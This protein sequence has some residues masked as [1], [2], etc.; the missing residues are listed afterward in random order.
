[1]ISR[2]AAVV[3]T[4]LALLVAGC[5]DDDREPSSAAEPSVVALG[6]SIPLNEASTCPGCDGFIDTYAEAVGA[7]V[8]NLAVHGRRVQGVADQL[9][10]GEAADALADADLVIVSFGA[11]DYPPYRG[12]QQPCRVADTP[13]FEAA[14]AALAATT[15]ACVG[16]VVRSTLRTAYDALAEVLDEAPDARLAVLAPY[17]F[18]VGWPEVEG[19]PDRAMIADAQR[20]MTYAV[21]VWR[22]ALCAV[23]ADLHGTCID[24]YTAFNGPD[25]DRP[26][27]DL[28]SSDH[29]HPSQE[30]NDLIRDLLLE[31]NLL[32]TRAS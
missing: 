13:T 17:D 32:P 23:V 27:G 8:D 3:V 21:R 15:T 2:T 11:N 1:M 20:T 25:G 4:S 12:T 28:L 22:D 19:V 18:W 30:G 14:V 16:R 9:A 26:A 5:S 24:L 7:R 31:A 10:A 6:D 29:T